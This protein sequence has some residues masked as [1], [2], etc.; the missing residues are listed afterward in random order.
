[1]VDHVM[2]TRSASLQVA[3]TGSV[4]VAGAAVSGAVVAFVPQAANTMA[5]TINKHKIF[6]KLPFIGY[7][8]PHD[9][10]YV[11]SLSQICF[12]LNRPGGK[13][14]VYLCKAYRRILPFGLCTVP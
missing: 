12:L 10:N 7:S 9:Q 14:L 13:S 8:P 4:V 2:G 3:A 1:M 11:E 5:P 6:H